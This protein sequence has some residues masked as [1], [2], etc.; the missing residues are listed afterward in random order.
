MQSLKELT[1]WYEVICF[2]DIGGIIDHHCL[3]FLVKIISFCLAM[4]SVPCHVSKYNPSYTMSFSLLSHYK[5]GA[6]DESTKTAGLA[7]P[8]YDVVGSIVQNITHLQLSVWVSVYGVLMPLST[9]FQL[10]RGGK[11]YWWTNLWR[12]FIPVIIKYS[13]F[14]FCSLLLFLDIFIMKMWG[15]HGDYHMIVVFIIIYPISAFHY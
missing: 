8:V 14:F 2:V 3:N 12:K 4:I 10:Y 7:K 15:C 5:R 6:V 9:I 1:A 13:I 11:F